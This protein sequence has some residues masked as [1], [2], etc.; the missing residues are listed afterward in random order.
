MAFILAYMNMYMK[1]PLEIWKIL[2]Y[3]FTSVV[4]TVVGYKVID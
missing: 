4:A 1:I 3:V 2:M